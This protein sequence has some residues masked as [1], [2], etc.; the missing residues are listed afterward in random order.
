[1]RLKCVLG[2]HRWEI[3]WPTAGPLF[4]MQVVVSCP[5]GKTR[6]A[7]DE[8]WACVEMAQ[9]Y[10][11]SVQA[12]RELRAQQSEAQRFAESHPGL[13]APLDSSPGLYGGLVDLSKTIGCSA[14]LLEGRH[15]WVPICRVCGGEFGLVRYHLR[16]GAPPPVPQFDV[17]SHCGVRRYHRP[18]EFLLLEGAVLRSPLYSSRH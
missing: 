13:F 18:V 4:R 2:F 3:S 10:H 7:S 16:C 6:K 5:C 17:C 12:V 15:H 1:M 9:E 14:I 11:T 8:E